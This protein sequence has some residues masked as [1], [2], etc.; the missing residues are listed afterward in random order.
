MAT[1]I[2]TKNSTTASTAP[3]GLI[4][5]EL[6]VNITDKKLY[7]GDSVGNSIQIAGQGATNGAGGSNTQVQYNSSGAL[8]GSSNMTFNGTGLTLAN[9]ASISGLTVGKGNSTIATNSVFGD[10]AGYA[11]TTAAQS[12]GI[13]YT[14]LRY[15][16]TGGD[17]TAIG[18][19]AMQQNTTGANNTSVG[20]MALIS[21]TT[22]S[23]NTALGFSALYTNS[24]GTE[25]TAVGT[26][27]LYYNTASYNSSLGVNALQ[28]NSTGAGNSALG[29]SALKTNTTG[30]SNTSVGYES[31]KSNTTA[32]NNT[33]VGYQAGYSN[34]TGYGFT[35]IGYQAG[36]SNTTNNNTF[37]GA[38]SGYSTTS[39]FNNAA[40]GEESLKLNTTGAQNAAF[41]MFALYSNTTASNNTA[42]GYQAGYNNQTGADC[43]FIG[44]G[45]GYSTTAG[46]N[47]FV[48]QQAG[49]SATS[50][51]L[52][53]FIGAAAG[54]SMTT[55][56]KNTIVGGFQGNQG[57]LDIRTASN[58]IVLSDGDGNPR[59]IF[60]SSGNF[61][62]G[63][64]TISTF[65]LG[66]HHLVASQ[67]GGGQGALV[68]YNSN[69]ADGATAINAVKNSSTTSSSARFVQFYASAG[70]QPMGGIVGNG[71]TN[72]QF[73]SISDAREKTNIQPLN[74]SLEKI[75]ALKPV[76]FDWIADGSHVPAGFVAQDVQQVFP[77]YVVENMSNDGEEQRYGLTGGMT[78]GI[79]PHLVKAIQ[80]LKAEVDSL[81]QQLGK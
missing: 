33:A 30:G 48:G 73:A 19:G 27:A 28:N 10:H 62:A 77:E 4:Q 29:H 54:Y 52:N 5:G 6:A 55:G 71:A 41:G 2:K 60:D 16:T 68:A 11:I 44:K 36:Y 58:Y 59:G 70:S 17:N 67:S 18:Y 56:A 42:V 81:K 80:E 45:A 24:T 13:G 32:S 72:V 65:N 75:N 57:G 79:I 34:T 26:N 69:A 78:G 9:D 66:N 64:T 14:A 3:T 22:A 51:T 50:G 20:S 25:N 15:A 49:Y 74:G 53:T 37:V 46:N 40:L 12:T 61:L 35:A 23:Y 47:T 1:T 38:Q 43:V 76:E 21:N 63:I 8:A 39:G 7:V 31:L